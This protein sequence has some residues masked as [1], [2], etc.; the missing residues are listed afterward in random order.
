MRS[1]VQKLMPTKN[2]CRK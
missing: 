2:E 1:N